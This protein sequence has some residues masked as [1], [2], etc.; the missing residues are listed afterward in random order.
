VRKGR[1]TV[2]DQEQARDLR[3]L[4]LGRGEDLISRRM[5]VAGPEE[6]LNR[7]L[8]LCRGIPIL[9]IN[10]HKEKKPT[11]ISTWK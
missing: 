10:I 9:L 7:V 11:V 3:P 6:G 2:R 4:S 5:G 8:L 1:R